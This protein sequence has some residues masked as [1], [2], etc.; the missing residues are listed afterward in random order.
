MRSAGSIPCAGVSQPPPAADLQVGATYSGASG[1]PVRLSCRSERVYG[2]GGYATLDFKYHFGVEVNIRQVNTTEPTITVYERTYE[3][4]GRYV[5][6]Y[7][8]FNPYLGA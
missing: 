2:F 6:H 1:V 5:R 7:G 4:G 8:R 3:I